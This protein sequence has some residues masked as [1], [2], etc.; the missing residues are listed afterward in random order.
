MVQQ[1]T[2]IEVMKDNKMT[3]P[4]GGEGGAIHKKVHSPSP[5]V[6]LQQQTITT[7]THQDVDVING[8]VDK[9]LT[10]KFRSPKF[11]DISDV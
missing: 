6:L 11:N 8:L 3:R 10:E 5:E 4:T 7:R 1:Q 9:Q 2:V